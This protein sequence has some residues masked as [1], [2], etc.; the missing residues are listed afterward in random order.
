MIEIVIAARRKNLGG[1]LEVGRV[2]PFAQRRMVGPFVFLDHMGPADF[3]PGE[4]VDV[5]PHPHIGLATVTYLF[6]GELLHHDSLGT[7]QPI[8]PGEVNWMTAGRGIVHSE[9]TRPETRARAR[10][11][12]GIQA[13]V[14]LPAEMEETAP[15]F[16]HSENLPTFAEGGIS[17]TLIAGHFFGLKAGAVLSPLFYVHLEMG[18]GSRLTLPDEHRERA[19]YVARGTID[20]DHTPIPAGQMAVFAP[21]PAR[22]DAGDHPARVMLLG[23]EPLGPRHLWWNFVSSRPERIA[24]AK[25]DWQAGRMPLPPSDS[26]EFIPLPPEPSQPSPT[27]P[28]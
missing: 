10:T 21:G 2:L 16:A 25:A 3:A 13:W 14:A 23:G 27:D 12:D 9:R 7:V 22:I 1:G 5:R 15:A 24:Q 20:A 28:V 19:A 6:D 8:L 26:G 17:G 18:P 11:M 4:G